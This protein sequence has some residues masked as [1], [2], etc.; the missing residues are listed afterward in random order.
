M[1]SNTSE[2]TF[3]Q[4][5][6]YDDPNLSKTLIFDVRCTSE[7]G[8]SDNTSFSITI[9]DINDNIPACSPPQ[10]TF[11]LQYDHL[12]N[13]TLVNL[14]CGDID[15]TVN[16]ELEYSTLG[17]SA[18]YTKQYFYVDSTGNVSLATSFAMDYNTSFYVTLLVNDRGTPSLST[19]VTLTVTYTRE[20]KIVTYT[21]V[22]PCFLCTTSAITL[23]ASLCLVLFMI[24]MCLIVLCVLRCCHSCEMRSIR[25]AFAKV[26]KKT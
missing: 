21:R 17:Y 9:L 12:P 10:T 7:G 20:I 8:L 1:D 5:F 2:V 3:S 23:V 11:N 4:V 25:K 24:L 6:D 26:K 14:D 16:A 15:S 19:T 18:G 22:S 13:V